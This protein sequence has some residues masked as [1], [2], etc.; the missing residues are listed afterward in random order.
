MFPAFQGEEIMEEIFEVIGVAAIPFFVIRWLLRW[1]ENSDRKETLKWQTQKMAEFAARI[2][3]LEATIESLK[4]E[5]DEKDKLIGK[6]DQEYIELCSERTSFPDYIQ[7]LFAQ[8]GEG[9]DLQ[10]LLEHAHTLYV[11]MEEELEKKNQEI[12]QLQHQA[13]TFVCRCNFLRG[14]LQKRT[15]QYNELVDLAR[16]KGIIGE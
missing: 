9:S 3:E 5:I 2:K 8:A 14:E 7:D 10:D 13:Q 16:E 11:E 15:D 1:Q 6:Q 12:A 4:K